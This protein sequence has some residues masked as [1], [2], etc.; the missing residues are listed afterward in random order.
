MSLNYAWM[1]SLSILDR[2]WNWV[3][4]TL[5]LISHQVKCKK[6]NTFCSSKSSC[7]YSP[8]YSPPW[9]SWVW[10][11]IEIY[12]VPLNILYFIV[13][14]TTGHWFPSWVRQHHGKEG[15][16]RSWEAWLNQPGF[17]PFA[18]NQWASPHPQTSSHHG[19]C[20]T[21]PG[22][23]Q[24]GYGLVGRLCKPCMWCCVCA[25]MNAICRANFCL[26]LSWLVK[27]AYDKCCNKIWT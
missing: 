21:Q 10:N 17:P 6:K 9:S 20:R 8:V 24:P 4:R 16:R 18:V 1:F 12:N 26:D 19:N 3:K 23:Q 27:N 14:L 7:I 22:L 2:F 5:S 13:I 11:N 15:V 25:I